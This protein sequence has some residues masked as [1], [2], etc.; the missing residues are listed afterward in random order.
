MT[1]S[2]D[3]NPSCMGQGQNIV[4]TDGGKHVL[5]LDPFCSFCKE[6]QAHKVRRGR[7]QGLSKMRD[8]HDKSCC[9]TATHPA[10]QAMWVFEGAG[11][12]IARQ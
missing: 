1:P 10:T 2:L 9:W 11:D 6:E 4:G 8:C 5:M 12:T 7:F 3:S